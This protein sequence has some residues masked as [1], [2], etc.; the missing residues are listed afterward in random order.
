MKIDI[1]FFTFYITENSQEFFARSRNS[2]FPGNENTL[3]WY[4]CVFTVLSV[5]LTISR[6][7]LN[8]NNRIIIINIIITLINSV[9]INGQLSFSES[10]TDDIT[11]KPDEV[12][13]K[14]NL[15]Q[16]LDK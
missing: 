13:S 10:D 1:L 6:M 4:V 11:I 3:C 7:G 9:I 8:N 5:H 12:I 16:G 2:Q 14:Y 15:N